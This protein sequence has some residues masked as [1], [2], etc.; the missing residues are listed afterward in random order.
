MLTWNINVI[1]YSSFEI[2]LTKLLDIMR[3][4]NKL[5][6]AE[7]TILLSTLCFPLMCS[8]VVN[9]GF[10]YTILAG[11]SFAYCPCPQTEYQPRRLWYTPLIESIFEHAKV[12]FERFGWKWKVLFCL[13]NENRLNF[14][15]AFVFNHLLA[16]V[17]K[18]AM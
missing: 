10:F 1:S 8:Q 5:K 16:S 13:F 14:L 9:I 6:H 15:K 11:V 7:H 18:G 4:V 2:P 17:F 12:S 3:A